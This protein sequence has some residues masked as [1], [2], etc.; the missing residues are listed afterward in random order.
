MSFECASVGKWMTICV[1]GEWDMKCEGEVDE[2]CGRP[3]RGDDDDVS[4]LRSR[5][6]PNDAR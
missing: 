3:L 2:R 4:N 6:P 5:H 1:C